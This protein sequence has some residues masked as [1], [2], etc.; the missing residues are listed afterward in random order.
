[1]N[2]N[3]KFMKQNLASMFGGGG[4]YNAPEG[5]RKI[6]MIDAMMKLGEPSMKLANEVTGDI[7]VGLQ[8]TQSFWNHTMVRGETV[9]KAQKKE[10]KNQTMEALQKDLKLN[11][12]EAK[13]FYDK[14]IERKEHLFPNEVQTGVGMDVYMR[15]D[16]PAVIEKFDYEN[17]GYKDA[18]IKITEENK[19]L[20]EDIKQ[21]DNYIKTKTDYDEWE[22]HYFNLEEDCTEQYEKWLQEKG[23]KEHIR[24]FSYFVPIYVNFIYNYGHTTTVLL[25]KV[26]KKY[27]NEF[28]KNFVIRK[29]TAEPEQYAKCPPA[30][31]YFYIFLK[32]IGYL[33]STK[34]TLNQ[35]SVQEDKFL[36]ILKKRG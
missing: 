3:D 25:N 5:F 17:S 11:E 1:M 4:N 19:I 28:F 13:E 36:K 24:T 8:I 33:E 27:Y 23:L 35:L 20:V 14:L 34:R 29:T 15:V 10:F 16:K 31:K 6:S 9:T 7:N 21:M 2:K 18:P 30:I 32:E 26:T 12:Q 22:D